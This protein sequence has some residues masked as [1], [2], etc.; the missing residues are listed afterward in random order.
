MN[1]LGFWNTQDSPRRVIWSVSTDKKTAWELLLKEKSIRASLLWIDQKRYD[2]ILDRYFECVDLINKID[3]FLVNNPGVTEVLRKPLPEKLRRE[4]SLIVWF[5]RDATNVYDKNILLWLEAIKLKIVELIKIVFNGNMSDISR[6][7]FWHS[8][9]RD[10]EEAILYQRMM[11]LLS[12]WRRYT[13]QVWYDLS[14]WNNTDTLVT[15]NIL[16]YKYANIA[17]LAWIHLIESDFT[18]APPWTNE[19]LIWELGKIERT[20]AMLWVYDIPE[21]EWVALLEEYFISKN[22]DFIELRTFAGSTSGSIRRESF[23]MNMEDIWHDFFIKHIHVLLTPEANVISREVM[24]HLWEDIYVHFITQ[25]RSEIGQREKRKSE[26]GVKPWV[27]RAQSKVWIPIPPITAS[28]GTSHSLVI[29][30]PSNTLYDTPDIS[31]AFRKN[32]E[33]I[34]KSNV[35]IQREAL[36]RSIPFA[37]STLLWIYQPDGED[38]WVWKS[39]KKWGTVEMIPLAGFGYKFVLASRDVDT[40]T[41]AKTG[42]FTQFLFTKKVAWVREDTRKWVREA[43]QPQIPQV[44]SSWVSE[45]NHPRETSSLERDAEEDYWVTLAIHLLEILERG[46]GVWEY[47]HSGKIIFHY[48]LWD[49]D[50]DLPYSWSIFYERES[51][52]ITCVAI[53]SVYVPRNLSTIDAHFREIFLEKEWEYKKQREAKEQEWEIEKMRNALRWT[54]EYIEK[55][56]LSLKW[57]DATEDL[58]S[59]PERIWSLRLGGKFLGIKFIGSLYE[60]IIREKI[61]PLGLHMKFSHTQDQKDIRISLSFEWSTDIYG[62]IESISDTPYY[63]MSFPANISDT[64]KQELNQALKNILEILGIA[65]KTT[66]ENDG[67]IRIHLRDRMEDP[68]RYNPY[69]GELTQDGAKEAYERFQRG[70]WKA[71]RAS[72]NKDERRYYNIRSWV[73]TEELKDDSLVVIHDETLASTDGAYNTSIYTYILESDRLTKYMMLRVMATILW[74]NYKWKSPLTWKMKDVL[75]FLWDT[76]TQVEQ[77]GLKDAIWGSAGK[78]AD[79]MIW[80]DITFSKKLLAEYESHKVGIVY[81]SP[82]YIPWSALKEK[83]WPTL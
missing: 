25:A 43:S 32:L 45:D 63:R 76:L 47:E 83:L 12:V 62:S 67:G 16:M 77:D 72:Y 22:P 65:G 56:L 68:E 71:L 48:A 66:T 55:V 79:F 81:R 17:S 21:Q 74:S 69:L 64:M 54:T 80:G 1:I 31:A 61:E 53:D 46:K 59:Y 2:A 3:A 51:D 37:D 23:S 57:R 40:V 19:R 44:W 36:M 78:W 24:E 29:E 82:K 18:Q 52:M 15:M 30:P 35:S 13:K 4:S 7:N 58:L 49:F 70:E 5:D 14:A 9:A 26:H 10:R 42:K 50:W 75:R 8:V 6:M 34:K 73:K 28:P 11:L 60:T 33:K 38:G 27:K 20:Y 39:Y 41:I